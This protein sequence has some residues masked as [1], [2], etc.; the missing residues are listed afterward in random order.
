MLSGRAGSSRA[1]QK[2]D[3]GNSGP[4]PAWPDCRATKSLPMSG[5]TEQNTTGPSG[6]AFK[7]MLILSAQA[8]PDS[9]IGPTFAAQAWPDSMLWPTGWAIFGLGRAGLPMPRYDSRQ[10]ASRASP[11][12][13]YFAGVFLHWIAVS[14]ALS[15]PQL[16]HASSASG[17][18]A[19]MEPRRGTANVEGHTAQR[20]RLRL[21]RY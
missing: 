16:Q 20:G 6:Q 21:A 5:P 10:A 14:A 18:P 7:K 11:V 19:V 15:L 12:R 13:A 1:K 9:A 4:G 3:I 2:P 8:R 17:N